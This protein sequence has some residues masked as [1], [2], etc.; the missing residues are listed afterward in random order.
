MPRTAR[1]VRSEMGKGK[2]SIMTDDQTFRLEEYK[3]LRKEIEL[4]LTESR[5]QE[6]YTLI[7]VGA[8]WAWLMINRLTSGLLWSVPIILTVAAS[9]RMIAILQHFTHMGEYIKALEGKF[10]VRGWEHKPKG[11]TLGAA[12]MLLSLA[13]LV[14]AIVAFSYRLDLLAQ[15]PSPKQ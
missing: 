3:S 15:F 10:T 6:R 9:I 8:I 12:N 11:W 14:L 1:T 7:A 4:Y 13:L 2:L 5:S